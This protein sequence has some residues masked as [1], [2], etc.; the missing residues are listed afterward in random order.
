LSLQHA[1]R[2]NPNEVSAVVD[3]LSKPPVKKAEFLSGTG[4]IKK[5]KLLAER[6]QEQITEQ[7]GP[8]TE[9]PTLKGG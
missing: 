4:R 3:P 7:I 5:R 1:E 6:P 2:G 9:I 8:K